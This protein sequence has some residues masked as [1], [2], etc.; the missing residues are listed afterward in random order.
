MKRRLRIRELELQI[1]GGG[2]GWAL[3]FVGFSSA[4]PAIPSALFCRVLPVG[5]SC[6]PP[7]CALHLNELRAPEERGLPDARVTN[8]AQQ[9]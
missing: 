9:P 3:P 4:A 1:K 7:S 5:C 2:G 6:G 8:K